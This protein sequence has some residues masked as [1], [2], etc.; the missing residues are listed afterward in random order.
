MGCRMAG[1]AMSFQERRD[2]A[3]YFIIF[4]AQIMAFLGDP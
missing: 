3:Q 1:G 2:V 4:E